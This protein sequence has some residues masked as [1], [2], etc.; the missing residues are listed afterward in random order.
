MSRVRAVYGVALPLSRVFEEP[1]LRGFAASVERAA[2]DGADEDHAP[3]EPVPRDGELSLSFAQQ[4]LW[5]VDQMSPDAGAYN[6][7]GAV[8][9]GGDLSVVALEQAMGEIVRRHEVLRTRYPSRL[10][11]PRQEIEPPRPLH[12]PVLEPGAVLGDDREPSL[13]KLMEGHLGRPFSLAR[14]P[15]FRAILYRLEPEHH[16]LGFAIHH[17]A[18][19]GWSMGLLVRELAA[20]YRSALEGRPSPLPE[21]RVQYAD[22]AAWQRSRMTGET[23]RRHLDFWRRR[24]AGA[25]DRL[26]LPTDRPRRPGRSARGAVRSHR[27]SRELTDGL[28]DLSRELGATLFMALLAA[29]QLLLGRLSGQRDVLVGTD[30]AGRD[31]LETEPLIGF[32]INLLALRVRL[33]DHAT[34]E[35]LVRDVRAGTLAAY[36]HQQLP[37]E[38]LVEEVAPRRSSTGVPLIQA[39][40]VMQNTPREELRLPGCT[41]APFGVE[42]GWSKFE[43]A[44]FVSDRGD[45]AD[46]IEL[47]WSYAT[48]LFDPSTIDRMADAFETLLADLVAH[49]ESRLSDLGPAGRGERKN[50][51]METSGRREAKLKKFLETAPRR[52]E[53]PRDRLVESEGPERGRSLLRTIRPAVDDLDPFEWAEAHREDLI[54]QL[55]ELGALRFRGFDLPTVAD[56]ER[57]ATILCPDLFS[58][59]GDLPKEGSSDKVYHSTPYPADKWILFHNE[60]SHMHRWPLRQFFYSVCVAAEGGETPLLDCREVRRELDPAIVDRLRER[61]VMYVRNFRPGFDVP[62]QDFFRTDDRSAVEEY[63]RRAGIELEWKDDGGLRTRQRAL[64][65]ARHPESGEEVFFN[66]LQLHHPACLEPEVRESLTALF[67]PEEL[68]RNV[69][70]GDGEPIESSILDE[71]TGLYD[72]LA[73]VSPWQEGDV[74]MVDNML[75]AHARKPFSG[76][77]KIVVAMGELVTR[78]EVEAAGEVETR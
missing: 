19:D 36:A 9:L 28:R 39:L 60:S 21:L 44:V 4:R 41:L 8:R 52:T 72:E 40:F 32:F 35:E 16:V 76:D 11:E 64:A 13:R 29:F 48:E 68:P 66:Q 22:F 63:C 75:T 65:V 51:T 15:L 10:G 43:I 12:L 57:F 56:F 23:A 46:G 54:A 77:R 71:I 70:Y 42:Q 78:A 58:E 50:R 62:W 7:V 38:M 59:Y 18:A 47:H 33:D 26:D 53:R 31:R 5:V 74:V 61:E 34:F 24:L 27:L 73:V 6:V 45:R 30:V 14:G 25:P 69:L 3:I 20:L 2:G 1:T 67:G 17:I 49:P 37:F 55:R